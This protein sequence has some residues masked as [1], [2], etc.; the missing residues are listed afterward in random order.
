LHQHVQSRPEAAAIIDTRRWRSRITSFRQLEDAAARAA[1]LL[2]QTGLRPGDAVL[3][4]HPMSAELYAALLALFRLGTVAM[5]RAP[6]AGKEHSERCCG[7]RR[8]RALI[9]GTKAHLLRL[10]SPALRAIPTK[11]VIGFPV[12]GAVSWRRC[13]RATPHPEILARDPDTPALLTF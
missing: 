6:S 11:F 2:W 3:V 1:G 7:L 8:P 12:P 9:A 5:F 13:N 4:F 10:R